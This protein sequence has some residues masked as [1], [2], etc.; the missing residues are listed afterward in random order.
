MLMILTGG[1]GAGLEMVSRQVTE[2]RIIGYEA[3]AQTGG[4]EPVPI[5]LILEIQSGGGDHAGTSVP[6]NV[7]V[8]EQTAL[9]CS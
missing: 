5:I 1:A 6:S 9:R 8:G 7:G 2:I 4:L 3:F